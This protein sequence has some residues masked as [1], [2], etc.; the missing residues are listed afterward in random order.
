[1]KFLSISGNYKVKITKGE[2]FEISNDKDYIA[3][4]TDFSLKFS[5]IK[6][7]LN[8]DYLDPHAFRS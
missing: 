6:K 8:E 3:R 7:T 1:M 5:N 2:K 4:Q